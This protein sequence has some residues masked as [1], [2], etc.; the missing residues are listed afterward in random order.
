MLA[1]MLLPGAVHAAECPTAAENGFMLLQEDVQ[2]E[3]RRH[4]GPIVKIVNRHGTSA[5][6][7]VF[8][9]RGLIDLSRMDAESQQAIYALSDL[10]NIFP[11][12]KGAKH[13]ISFVLLNPDRSDE[14]QL[15]F[16]LAVTGQETFELEDCK[17]KVLKIR[18]TTK[19]G[20]EQVDVWSALY[21]PDLEATLAKIYD[22]GTD[23]EYMVRYER[24][25][26]L[27]R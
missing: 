11:L 15:T 27:Q 22:E 17:Y 23:K 16:E 3:F 25:R 24:I 2:S 10:K 20:D 7:T 14:G 1:A 13:T 5:R 4:H 9:Y 21:S 26:P 8:S 18:Q 6:Q 19:K 12:K